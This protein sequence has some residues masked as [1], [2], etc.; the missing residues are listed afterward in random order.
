[1]Q[2]N[3][4]DVGK[5]GSLMPSRSPR[6][7]RRMKGQTKIRYLSDRRKVQSQI[8]VQKR[9]SDHSTPT[10]SGSHNWVFSEDLSGQKCTMK[11]LGKLCSAVSPSVG[12]S[13]LEIN[14]GKC[15]P[16]PRWRMGLR[17]SETCNRL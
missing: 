9:S 13:Q 3:L 16:K 1:M 7:C 2:D 6:C 17:P 8:G 14:S 5:K 10:S 4:E 12:Y 15:V 11:H